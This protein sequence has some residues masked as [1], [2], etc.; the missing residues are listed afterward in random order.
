[1]TLAKQE[2]L[3]GKPGLAKVGRDSLV[4]SSEIEDINQW[5]KNVNNFTTLYSIPVSD[6]FLP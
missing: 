2:M 6:E 4:K 1:M 3:E 5:A